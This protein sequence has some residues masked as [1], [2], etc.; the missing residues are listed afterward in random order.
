MVLLSFEVATSLCVKAENINNK[1]ASPD[2]KIINL[3]RVVVEVVTTSLNVVCQMTQ[4]NKNN[5]IASS[6]AWTTNVGVVMM[7]VAGCHFA[8][9]L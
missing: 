7:E 2:A 1:L 5:Q 8:F 6:A 4:K 9:P 3:R